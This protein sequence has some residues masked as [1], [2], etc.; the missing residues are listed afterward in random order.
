MAAVSSGSSS[1]T[2]WR[3][4]VLCWGELRWGVESWGVRLW[5]A[6]QWDV[7]FWGAVPSGVLRSGVF[8]SGAAWKGA[9]CPSRRQTPDWLTPLREARQQESFSC[10]E[11]SMMGVLLA[12]VGFP[13]IKTGTNQPRSTAG[14]ASVAGSDLGPMVMVVSVVVVVARGKCRTCKDQQKQ[15]SSNNFHHGKN[16]ARWRCRWLRAIHGESRKEPL[17]DSGRVNVRS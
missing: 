15:G 16:V 8:R 5:G 12:R 10:D 6:A 4:S 9:D 3:W 14:E 17:P 11:S 7:V 13:S 1:G 2:S